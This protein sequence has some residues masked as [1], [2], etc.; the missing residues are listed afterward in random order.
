MP[1]SYMTFKQAGLGVIPYP[2]DFKMD[3][4]YTVY[5]YFP[6]M[7]VLQDS[8]KAIREYIGLFAYYL[9]FSFK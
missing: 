3:K 2:T 6:K 4:K 8:T 7:S 1:R 5:S 9:R